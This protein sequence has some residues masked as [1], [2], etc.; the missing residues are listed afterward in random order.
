MS[1][2]ENE[3]SRLKE[4]VI[5]G[6]KVSDGIMA[7]IEE[8]SIK[9]EQA[10]ASSTGA[11]YPVGKFSRF[12]VQWPSVVMIICFVVSAG[13]A[14][15]AVMNNAFNALGG[16][17]DFQS[18]IVRRNFAV[19]LGILEWHIMLEDFGLWEVEDKL[20]EDRRRLTEGSLSSS[21]LTDYSSRS[22]YQ[23][24]ARGQM[25]QQLDTSSHP[26]SK[27]GH[28]HHRS[29]P[30]LFSKSFKSLFTSDYGLKQEEE[31]E[32]D[33]INEKRRML[34]SSNT[35]AKQSV[36]YDDFSIVFAFRDKSGKPL[37]AKTLKSFKH[38]QKDLYVSIPGYTDQC[39][40]NNE[41]LCTAGYSIVNWAHFLDREARPNFSNETSEVAQCLNL[42]SS[43]WNSLKD[44]GSF[45]SDNYGF[46]IPC[47]TYDKSD[48]SFFSF[49]PF[50]INEPMFNALCHNGTNE[51]GNCGTDLSYVREFMLGNNWD[52]D[53][54]QTRYSRMYFPAAAPPTEGGSCDFWNFEEDM[55]ETSVA[56][57]DPLFRLKSEIE[58]VN[59]D[60]TF[61]FYFFD[62]FIFIDYYL[63]K[64]LALLGLS[65]ALVFLV[66]WFQ[67][68]S[69]FITLC[70]LYEIFISFPLGLFVWSV[71]M[72][73][74]AVT[75]LMY[76]GIF[77][78]LGIGCDDIFGKRISVCGV[79]FFFFNI[80]SCCF[81]SPFFRVNS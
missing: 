71:L 79:H 55:L 62:I 57:I 38:A 21:P 37:S 60:V 20:I 78:I 72:D 66:L 70:G 5:N 46:D 8:L 7:R 29:S 32:D 42:D 75:Y 27:L 34:S 9:K 18:I 80:T 19:E 56:M 69:V 10:A 45:C 68:S 65:F 4:Y 74:P 17:T 25:G 1:Q 40:L 14:S 43:T 6:A 63:S 67:T 50:E 35:C 11:S 22:S 41:S 64:D 24:R 13:L 28:F 48:A 39:L 77:I 15:L 16:W 76:N 31:G 30:N 3:L 53:T 47:S 36:L 61:Y 12:I 33:E 58:A 54:L 81:P 59:N 73:E 2:E 23:R 51:K 49:P 52:C 44:K 26:N